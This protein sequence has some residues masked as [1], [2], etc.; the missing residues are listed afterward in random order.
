MATGRPSAFAHSIFGDDAAVRRRRCFA[1]PTPKGSWP[2]SRIEIR[3][4]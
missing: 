3:E 1:A 2:A 4:S